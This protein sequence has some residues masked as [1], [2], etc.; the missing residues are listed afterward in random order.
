MSRGRGCGQR[1][2]SEK[3]DVKTDAAPAA[4]SVEDRCPVCLEDYSDKAFVESCF[5]I[6][7]KM[8]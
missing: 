5:R 2:M 4:S 1:K 6:L 3:D 7:C 8:A